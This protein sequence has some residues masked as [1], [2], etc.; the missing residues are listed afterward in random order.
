MSC[1]SWV[2]LHGIA[3]SFSELLKPLRHDKAAICEGDIK[4]TKIM[5]TGPI[6]SWQ[7]A[8]E[9]MEAVTDFTFVGSMITCRW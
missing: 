6:T 3:Q 7:I 9:D 4:K 1:P 8:G 2:V 5:A